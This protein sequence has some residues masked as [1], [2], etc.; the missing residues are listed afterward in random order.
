MNQTIVSIV[1]AS[2][3]MLVVQ[4]RPSYLFFW[5]VLIDD[6]FGV[7]TKLPGSGIAQYAC[8]QR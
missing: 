7:P 5:E 4:D 8:T 2:V 3:A 6:P 1:V